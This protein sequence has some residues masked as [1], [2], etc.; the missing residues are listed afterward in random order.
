LSAFPLGQEKGD[1]IM[2]TT[3]IALGV[4]A[5]STTTALAGD[6]LV[7]V[8]ELDGAVGLTAL[9]LVAGLGAIVYE[10]YFRK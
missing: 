10:K 5:L 9:G 8:P 2:K 6:P 4:M 1:T 3:L 7:A